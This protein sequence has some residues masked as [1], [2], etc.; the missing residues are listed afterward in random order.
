L[1]AAQHQAEIDRLSEALRRDAEILALRT[2]IVEAYATQLSNG[3]I[4]ATDYLT[5]R[6]AAHQADVQH[7][8]NKLLRLQ[9]RLSLTLVTGE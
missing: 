4:T 1:Q 9:A 7:R 8:I 3:S 2:K 5:E 6:N